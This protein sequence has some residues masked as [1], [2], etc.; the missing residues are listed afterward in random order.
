MGGTA[1]TVNPLVF[2][3]VT[4]RRAGLANYARSMLETTSH[5]CVM[6][7]NIKQN[8]FEKDPPHDPLTE[9]ADAQEITA[10]GRTRESCTRSRLCSA[11]H[12][13]TCGVP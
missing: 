3:A 5:L 4:H 7:G 6:A 2:F 1:P 10:L 12:F 8:G 11:A 13:G 9:R